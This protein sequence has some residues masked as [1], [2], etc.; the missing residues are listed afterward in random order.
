[1]PKRAQAKSLKRE[2]LSVEPR[3]GFL[4][5]DTYARIKTVHFYFY[6]L[7][8]RVMDL[9]LALLLIFLLLPVMAIIAIVIKIDS[10]GSVLFKQE[11]VGKHGKVFKILKFR[12]MVCDNDMRDASCHDK[13]T[14]VGGVLRRLSLDELPQ[15]FNV[16]LG[17]MS[18]VGPRPW[19]VE[20]WTNM[21]EEER[22]RARVLP[23]ITG[24]AQVKG[25]NGISIFQ[26]I[27]YD[28]IYVE[29]FSLYQDVK[30]LV[31]TVVTVIKG[32]SVDA[33]KE[34]VRDDIRNLKAR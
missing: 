1:M 17:Q 14:R 29:N 24:L 18:F 32:D 10:P 4:S 11:R 22:G 21:N 25:R 13:Y 8:K 28:L 26:K 20:Y 34:G 9:V 6:G 7:V 3:V 2:T 5:A 30:V 15:L 12:S 23:G 16:L 19:V 27:Q 33:G 31:L